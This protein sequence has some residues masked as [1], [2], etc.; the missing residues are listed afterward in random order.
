M[1]SNQCTSICQDNAHCENKRKLGSM[2]CRIHQKLEADAG[3][4]TPG[5]CNRILK[6]RTRCHNHPIDDTPFCSKHVVMP[7]LIMPPPLDR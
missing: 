6:N 1:D 7:R 3:L 4:P 5:L 2:Y